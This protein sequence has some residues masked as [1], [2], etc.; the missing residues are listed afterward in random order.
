MYTKKADR[1]RTFKAKT[2]DR[3]YKTTNITEIL[4]SIDNRDYFK[5]F[6]KSLNNI[7]RNYNQEHKKSGDKTKKMRKVAT[8]KQFIADKRKQSSKPI[9]FAFQ[10]KSKSMKSLIKTNPKFNDFS[11]KPTGTQGKP[12]KTRFLQFKGSYN[13]N[14]VKSLTKNIFDIKA[15]DK[16]KKSGSTSKKT[17]PRTAYNNNTIKVSNPNFFKMVS[18]KSNKKKKR[19]PL[20]TKNTKNNLNDFVTKIKETNEGDE[21]V[22]LLKRSL[23]FNKETFNNSKGYYYMTDLHNALHDESEGMSLAL[24][25]VFQ[26]HFNQTIQSLIFFKKLNTTGYKPNGNTTSVG[27]KSKHRK[28]L[29]FDLDETLIHCKTDQSTESDV[30]VPVTFPG[31]E[32][33]VAG[34]NIRPYAKQILKNLSCHFEIIIFTASHSCYANPVIDFIDED[35]VV[36]KRLFRENCSQVTDGLFTKDLTIFKDRRLEDIILVDNAAYSF[37]FQLSNGVPIVPFTDNK[38]DRELY[39]L[40]KFLMTMIDIDDVREI[41]ESEFKWQSF[42][43]YALEPEKLFKNIK[44]TDQLI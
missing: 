17:N 6:K 27:K 37:F 28:T 33:I 43:R 12:L 34:I 2:A 16:K 29:I 35:K 9:R 18:K 39:K 11:R 8:S 38:E 3:Q 7:L 40:E 1:A 31:G 15:L 42:L 24:R 14:N 30:G 5:D 25:K 20:I 44:T 4:R 22:E 36:S 19:K 21:T 23:S 32:T 13:K 26:Q 10:T 41:I